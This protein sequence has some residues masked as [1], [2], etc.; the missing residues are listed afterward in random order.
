VTKAAFHPVA[1]LLVTV[2]LALRRFQ[3]MQRQQ[4]AT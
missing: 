1:V 3:A 2:L 4:P